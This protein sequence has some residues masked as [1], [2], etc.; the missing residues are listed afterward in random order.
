[1]RRKSKNRKDLVKAFVLATTVFLAG[2]LATAAE[3]KV[4]TV[5]TGGPGKYASMKADKNGNLHMAYVLDIDGHP[6]MYAFWDHALDRWFTMKV[7]GNASF[8]TLALDSHQRPH[9][10]YADH[11][12]GPGAKLRYVR[13]DG[14]SDWKVTPV[15]PAGDAT[16]AYYTSIALDAKDNPSFS[17]YDYA[18]PGSAGFTL[19]LRSVTWNGKFWEVQ[20]VDRDG[21]SGKFNSI[22]VDSS[23]RPRI[24]YA[25]VKWEN[26]GLRYAEWNGQEWKTESLEGV[27][28]GAAALANPTYAVS[29]VVDTSDVPHIVYTDVLHRQIKYATRRNGRWQIEIVDAVKRDSYPDRDGL[30]LDADGNPYVSYF[31]PGDGSFKVAHRSDGRWYV[32]LLTKD[33]SGFTSSVQIDNGMLWVAFG[34][35]QGGSLKV[36][37]RPLQEM[38]TIPV[39][40]PGPTAAKGTAK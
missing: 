10:S 32:E 22:A 9:I 35:E 11:G 17:Y 19:R 13:W 25:N 31:D 7:A 29:M 24:A 27:G 39:P 14:A 1:M 3:W 30:A 23:G 12:T 37:R 15:S 21:G 18:G 28:T 4:D 5:D 16:V 40:P 38:K 34:D 20:T 2:R 8:C 33:Y 36:A 6:L 26:S